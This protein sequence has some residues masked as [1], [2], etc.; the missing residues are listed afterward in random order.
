MEVNSSTDIVIGISIGIMVAIVIFYKI[1]ERQKIR[2]RGIKVEGVVFEIIDDGID[3][4]D[5]MYY[6]VVRYLTIEKEWITQRYD[7][8]SV[9]SRYK[10]GDVVSV[11]YDPKD[12]SKFIIDGKVK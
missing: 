3:F 2:A 6:P 9:P 5:R 1:K 4:S 12:I 7:V 11:I 10:E 8:G